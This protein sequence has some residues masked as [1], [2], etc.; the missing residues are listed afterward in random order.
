[1]EPVGSEHHAICTHTAVRHLASSTSAP[2]ESYE[3]K[4]LGL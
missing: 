1:M 3:G 4:S 2:G